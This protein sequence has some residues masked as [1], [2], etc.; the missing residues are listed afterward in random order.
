MEANIVDA[1]Q[2][3]PTKLAAL[4]D[5][6]ANRFQRRIDSKLPNVRVD[7]CQRYKSIYSSGAEW[8][9]TLPNDK[10]LD[11]ADISAQNQT[12]AMEIMD[13]WSEGSYDDYFEQGSKAY[14][15]QNP[16]E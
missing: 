3:T 6:E 9:R 11:V 5:S 13:C 7:E 12:L 14:F 8:A 2:I 1:V 10:M 4:C 16:D 15:E